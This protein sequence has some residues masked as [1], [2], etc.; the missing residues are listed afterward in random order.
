MEVGTG[1]HP[2]LTGRENIFLNGTILGMKKIDINK[3]LDQIIEFS[4]LDMYIDTPIKRYSSGMKVRLGFAVAC[5]LDSDILFVD[6]VLAVGDEE[7]R[8]KALGKMNELSQSSDKTILFVSHNLK[9]IQSITSKCILMENGKVVLK[10][11]QS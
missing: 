4:G 1:F 11:K 6:E 9:A 2:E 3:R 8:I 7:F 10:I 5:T